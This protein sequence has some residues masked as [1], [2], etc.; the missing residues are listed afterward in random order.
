M[1]RSPPTKRDSRTALTS[2]CSTIGSPGSSRQ[3]E[4][5]KP[6]STT[7][8]STSRRRP[9]LDRRRRVLCGVTVRDEADLLPYF[10]A[11]PRTPRGRSLSRRRQP[12]ARWNAQASVGPSQRAPLADRDAV[13]ARQRGYRTG[14]RC[15]SAVSVRSLVS[16][17]RP[18]ELLYY[19]DV[20]TRSLR[21]L[22][23]EL[24]RTGKVAMPAVL[25]D[26]YSDRP[27]REAVY[28]TGQDPVEVTPFFDRQFFH[29]RGTAGPWRNFEGFAGGLRQRAFGEDSYPFLSKIP[30]FRY[31]SD[32][33]DRGRRPQHERAARGSRIRTRRRPPF[34]VHGSFHRSAGRRVAGS[35]L[36]RG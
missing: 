4:V 23:E 34:Q 30:L 25:L 8:A 12:L 2:N 22:C 1:R 28:R 27:V 29:W 31:T 14:S 11:I 5:T 17:R 21:Q 13:L 24:E 19:P 26:M 10:L 35:P 9:D 16:R 6:R 15:S 32:R 18:Y 20:E 3:R 36:R 7:T 33:V